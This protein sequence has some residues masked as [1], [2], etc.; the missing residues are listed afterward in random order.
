MAGKHPKRNDQPGV[1]R[2]GRTEL[3]YAA[4]DG[5]SPVALARNIGNYDIA[6]FFVD[7]PE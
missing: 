5:V 3:H 1:D 2:M 6:Q 7:L 4:N